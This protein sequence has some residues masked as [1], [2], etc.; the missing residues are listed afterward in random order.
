[1][2]AHRA[3]SHPQH[4]RFC[5]AAALLYVCVCLHTHTTLTCACMFLKSATQDGIRC[6]RIGENIAL[7]FGHPPCD[8]YIDLALF[9]YSW[10]SDTYSMYAFECR[11]RICTR[12]FACSMRKCVHNHPLLGFSEPIT[13]II[14]MIIIIIIITR[15]Y[16][17]DSDALHWRHCTYTYSRPLYT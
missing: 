7:E 9:G 12:T 1:M 11:M 5:A 17:F 6:I 3:H 2:V 14:I 15:A 4:V 10:E 16:I 13:I 8:W